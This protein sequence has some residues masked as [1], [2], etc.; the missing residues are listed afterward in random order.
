[1]EKN[2]ILCWKEGLSVAGTDT[3]AE[4][5]GGVS[6]GVSGASGGGAGGTAGL[7]A[8]LVWAAVSHFWA[9]EVLVVEAVAVAAVAPAG[10]RRG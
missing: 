6:A 4:G 10:S 1:M 3:V 8:F 5:G 7:L 2:K 9:R